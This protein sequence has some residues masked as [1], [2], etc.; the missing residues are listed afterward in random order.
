MVA[1][2]Y[3]PPEHVPE[4]QACNITISQNN[5]WVVGAPLHQL[6]ILV[7]EKMLRRITLP[8]TSVSKP[9]YLDLPYDVAC[10]KVTRAEHDLKLHNEVVARQQEL[11]SQP[12]V[13]PPLV[14]GASL[15]SSEALKDLSEPSSVNV[16][17][18]LSKSP[19]TSVE[20]KTEVKMEYTW[21][22][23]K[24]LSD[25]Q[26]SDLATSHGIDVKDRASRHKQLNDLHKKGVVR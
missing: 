14:K 11:A 2:A 6:D 1:Y 21:E 8:T 3:Y 10:G 13:L 12:P 9:G 18:I 5:G 20:V 17:D 24:S 7:Q 4:M 22:D 19:A 23:A 16:L 15:L 26:V 25:K